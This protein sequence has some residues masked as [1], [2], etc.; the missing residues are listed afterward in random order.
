M[1]DKIV[2]FKAN[3]RKIKFNYLITWLIPFIG[4][5]YGIAEGFAWMILTSP[6]SAIFIWA[7]GGTL[8]LDMKNELTATK[9]ELWVSSSKTTYPL[10]DIKKFRIYQFRTGKYTTPLLLADFHDQSKYKE[11]NEGLSAAI[12]DW[13]NDSGVRIEDLTYFSDKPEVIASELN[14]LLPHNHTSP[15]SVSKSSETAYSQTELQ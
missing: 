13:F 3:V 10:K 5:T 1:E 11:V 8:L 12:D 2:S 14:A 4:F 15:T 7:I 6:I 9:K